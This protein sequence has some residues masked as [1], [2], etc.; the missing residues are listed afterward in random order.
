MEHH[1]IEIKE[2][3]AEIKA[4]LKEHMRRTS[5]AEEKLDPMWKAYTGIKWSLGAIVGLSVILG[6][7]AKIKGFL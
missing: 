4:D 1:V 7:I 5:A 3:L 6:A 2:D